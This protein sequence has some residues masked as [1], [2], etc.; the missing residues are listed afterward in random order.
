MEFKYH[1]IK[2]EGKSW[3]DEKSLLDSNKTTQLKPTH[4]GFS[5]LFIRSHRRA[6]LA[7]NIFEMNTDAA[8]MKSHT[9]D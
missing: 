6:V 3:S 7:G 5:S 1:C 4:K 9:F 8:R 2:F